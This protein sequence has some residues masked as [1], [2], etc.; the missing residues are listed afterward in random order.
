MIPLL[1]AVNCSTPVPPNNGYVDVM[2]STDMTLYYG[3]NE[4]YL[5]T[6]V[7]QATCVDQDTWSSQAQ[8]LN[9]TSNT[10]PGKS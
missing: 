6:E 4:G 8:Q 5:P 10:P 7:Y 1:M 3:C 2:L 9:C